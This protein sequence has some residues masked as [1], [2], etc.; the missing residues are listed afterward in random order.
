M[1]LEIVWTK[2]AIAGF[3][4]TIK[5][6]EKNFTDKEVKRF[7]KQSTEFFELLKLYPEMLEKTEKQENVYRG[8]IN[9]YTILT[10]RLVKKT[11][12]IQL[13]NIRSARRKPLKG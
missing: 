4:N 5:Y 2:R 9:K 13:I 11:N 6:I 7:V 10:Y 8:P 3:D 1:A 12:Q